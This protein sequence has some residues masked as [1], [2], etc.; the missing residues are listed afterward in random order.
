MILRQLFFWGFKMLERPPFSP[1]FSFRSSNTAF[2]E[3]LKQIEGSSDC[4]GLPMI[5]FLILPM[6]RVTRLPLLLDVGLKLSFSFCAYVGSF[7]TLKNLFVPF[8]FL[9]ADDLPEN[10]ERNSRVLC[11]GLG[12]SCHQQGNDAESQPVC[13]DF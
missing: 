8:R 2:K 9:L 12:V 7:F 13:D 6:Q 5:S 1:S 11:G 3:T 10:S 4:G